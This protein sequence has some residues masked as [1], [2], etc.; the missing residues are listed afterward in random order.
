ML[1]LAFGALSACASSGAGAGSSSSNG[2]ESDSE[3]TLT[4]LAAASLTESF[5]ALGDR[6]E[7]RHPA[8]RVRFSFDSS[9]TLAEQAVQGAPADVLATADRRTMQRAVTGGAV[10]GDPVVFASNTPVVVV[11][12]DNPA[13]ITSLDD[14]DAEA[15]SY[16]VC[17]AT[18][19][20][21][22]IA[23][24]VLADHGIDTP[25]RSR[26]VDGKAVLTKVRLGEADA[27]L[28]YATDA[29]AAGNRVTTVP[30]PHADRYRTSYPAAGLAA[31]GHPALAH[32]WLDLLASPAGRGVL[33]DAGFSTP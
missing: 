4:V 14:L 11:P 24:R 30:V 22:A 21:G 25:P 7:Q 3:R 12:A 5:T 33:T 19:P 1:A 23:D 13:A 2:G 28:V 20:C 26:E 10:A 18:A 9:A 16:V 15:V 32:Q 31:S 27:G 6:F 8:V 17:V 29:H